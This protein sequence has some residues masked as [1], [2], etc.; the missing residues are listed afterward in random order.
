MEKRWILSTSLGTVIYASLFV[1]K[2]EHHSSVKTRR[3]YF[4]TC[5]KG[6]L[7]DQETNTSAYL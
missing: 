2:K 1:M 5:R 7:C 4:D 6:R 3:F